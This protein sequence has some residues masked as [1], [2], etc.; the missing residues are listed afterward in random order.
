MPPNV[1]DQPDGVGVVTS[2]HAEV[3]VFLG[4][5]QLRLDLTGEH[6]PLHRETS[7]ELIDAALETPLWRRASDLR[8]SGFPFPDLVLLDHVHV[9]SYTSGH[10]WEKHF[11]LLLDREWLDRGDGV[12][13]VAQSHHQPSGVLL[14]GV[15]VLPV[16]LTIF[17]KLSLPGGAV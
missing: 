14:N 12:L 8:T 17:L 6:V 11:E 2:F 1:F 5:V 4:H 3:G 10:A 15:V 7:H 13:R 9:P 16:R